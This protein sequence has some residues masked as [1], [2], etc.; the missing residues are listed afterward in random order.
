MT[1]T[2]LRSLRARWWLWRRGFPRIAGATHVNPNTEQLSF[3][4]RNDDGSESGATWKV[5]VNTD[6]TQAVDENFRV[7]F[8]IEEDAGASF[9]LDPQLQY[10]LNGAGW[11]NVTGASSV[12]RATASPNVADGAATTNQLTQSGLGFVAG[13]FDEVDGLAGSQTLNNQHTEV[14]YCV[15][16]RS[17]DVNNGDT[18]QLRVT[19]AGTALNV[20]TQTPTITVS[21]AATPTRGRVSQAYFEAP[22][23]PTR[24]R[25][26]QAYVE[27]PLVPTRGRISQAYLETPLAP[28]RGRVS[29][30]YLEVPDTG[31]QPTRGLI[32]Q[33]YLQV[34]F[35]PTRGRAAQAYFQVPFAPTRGRISQAYF[36]V[37]ESGEDSGYE[38]FVRGPDTHRMR[39]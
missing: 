31:P 18:V 7:R 24:G 19:D 5:L 39:H 9:T 28:T 34:P 37:P 20:Y 8:E 12:V 36:Q 17:A 6:W 1:R 14:E 29:Q 4:G 35:V 38:P 30:A 16:I 15:Q 26:S 25:V 11:N 27:V 22:F 23:V 2:S 32:S 10:N 21:E 33:A 3:R 13:V